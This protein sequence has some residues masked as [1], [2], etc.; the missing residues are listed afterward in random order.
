MVAREAGLNL[1]ENI[2]ESRFNVLLFCIRGSA[3]STHANSAAKNQSL[4]MHRSQKIS[5]F[6]NR[7]FSGF[8]ILLDGIMLI[9][10][11]AIGSREN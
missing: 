6:S 1:D 10:V 9:E 5:I 4:C 3:C 7:L 2:I 11:K 8:A